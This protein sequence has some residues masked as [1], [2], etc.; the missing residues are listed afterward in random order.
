MALSERLLRFSAA[1]IPRLE[2]V[3]S[4]QEPALFGA[5]V[6]VSHRAWPPLVLQ[7][8]I[9]ALQERMSACEA[10]ALSSQGRRF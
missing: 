5:S 7:E 8:G 3:E 4:R 1:G 10:R 9:S 6:A 2:A